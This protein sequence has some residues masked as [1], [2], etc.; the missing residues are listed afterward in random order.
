MCC[1]NGLIY[2]AVS[3]S[4][5]S[6]SATFSEKKFCINKRRAKSRIQNQHMKTKQKKASVL[7]I[8]Y[9]L[10]WENISVRSTINPHTS[11]LQNPE[12]S[13]QGIRE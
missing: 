3:L 4:I 10:I 1:N 12:S 6:E 11:L 8:I 9:F 2:C 13:K 7:W 5:N